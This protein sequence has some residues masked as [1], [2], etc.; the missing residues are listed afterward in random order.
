MQ[1]CCPVTVHSEPTAGLWPGG[2]GAFGRLDPEV[3][4][5]SG[6]DTGGVPVA[7]GSLGTVEPIK[8]PKRRRK[9]KGKV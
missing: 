6:I 1:E 9:A 2:S 8:T 7:S 5:T 3:T 4:G